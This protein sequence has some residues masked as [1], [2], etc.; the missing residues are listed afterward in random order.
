MEWVFAYGSN[1]DRD[2][3]RRWFRERGRR[4]G[5]IGTTSP[6]TLRGHRLV[7]NY[8]SPS[9]GAGAANVEPHR[10][11]VVPGLAIEVDELTLSGLDVKEGR[12]L[13]YERSLVEVCLG[14]GASVEAWVYSVLPEYRERSPVAP[15]RHYLG[16]MIRAA[17]THGFPEWYLAELRAVPV[18]E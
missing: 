4:L 6:A 13:R 15:R 11:S 14:R 2:D 10:E 7:W 9:R 18:V 3:L 16:L 12:G 1:M 8:R 5:V 17:E